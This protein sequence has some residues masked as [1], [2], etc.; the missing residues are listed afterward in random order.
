M[1]LSELNFDIYWTS[2]RIDLFFFF[3]ILFLC[4]S[5]SSSILSSFSFIFSFG[6]LCLLSHD[7]PSRV[8]FISFMDSSNWF[9]RR[10]ASFHQTPPFPPAGR[11]V[12]FRAD[13]STLTF[14][15]GLN[16][17]E[18]PVHS[19]NGWNSIADGFC[20]VWVL[21]SANRRVTSNGF[22]D[23]PRIAESIN[24]RPSLWKNGRSPSMNRLINSAVQ[25]RPW[26]DNRFQRFRLASISHFASE[27]VSRNQL[28]TDD[29]FD[30]VCFFLNW[31]FYFFLSIDNVVLRFV[32]DDTSGTEGNE[33]KDTENWR[34]L[35]GCSTCFQFLLWLSRRPFYFRSRRRRSRRR[36]VRPEATPRTAGDTVAWRHGAVTEFWFSFT[37]FSNP[38]FYGAVLNWSRLIAGRWR[39]AVKSPVSL[40]ADA[41]KTWP[42]KDSDHHWVSS[43][44]L[45]LSLSLHPFGSI[46]A[47]WFPF[48]S[49]LSVGSSLRP[50]GSH[51]FFWV[52]LLP[53][54]LSSPSGSCLPNFTEIIFVFLSILPPRRVEIESLCTRCPFFYVYTH[55]PC[56]SINVFFST[57]TVYGYRFCFV[58]AVFDWWRLNGAVGQ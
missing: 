8:A 23:R 28:L 1:A 46:R 40:M 17:P 31:F 10:A 48:P 34:L 5:F 18:P 42:N 27:H 11:R 22:E 7:F 35:I 43:T 3:F 4:S 58:F 49:L 56:F 52:C 6:L 55:R 13:L 9:L 12:R 16:P 50:S 24:Q 37:G 41:T 32:C 2:T 25:R 26:F 30:K 47:F 33:D 39:N 38:E 21:A 14:A 29:C 53:T 54:P 19:W 20:G 51:L 57:N 45:S 36:F 15:L 44:I